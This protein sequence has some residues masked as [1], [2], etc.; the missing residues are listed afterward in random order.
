MKNVVIPFDSPSASS[1]DSS[2]GSSDAVAKKVSK[3]TKKASASVVSEASSSDSSVITSSGS[4]SFT[5]QPHC[6]TDTQS[7]C[8]TFDVVS[9]TTMQ[10]PTLN[11]GDTIDMDLVLQNPQLLSID[12]M[13][14]T[15]QYDPLF[16]SG[17]SVTLATGFKNVTASG[18]TFDDINGSVT[19]P[20]TTT[21]QNGN[22]Q[23]SMRIAEVS[24]TVVGNGNS[25]KS[26][27][28]FN[29]ASGDPLQSVVTAAGSQTNV[30]AQNLGMLAVNVQNAAPVSSPKSLNADSGSALSTA[31]TGSA[32]FVLLQPQNVKITTNGTS[33]YFAWDILPSPELVGY[34]IYYGSVSGAYIQRRSVPKEQTSLTI[35]SLPKGT[36]YYA[37]IR[38]VN[39]IGNETS[40]SQE[41]AVTVGDPLTSSAPFIPSATQGETITNPLA[42]HSAAPEVPGQSGLSTVFSLILL[43]SAIAGTLFALRRQRSASSHPFA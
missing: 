14:I 23:A 35:D 40:F 20:V 1:I 30:I 22:G 19:L 3:K 17:K 15:L 4:V 32:T 27:V 29:Q 31:E 2:A 33:L 42:R 21:T 39:T 13:R 6:T 5:L 38:G 18:I 7:D 28:T 24:F 11:V 16:L 12:T 36:T 26:V 41:V 8:P 37:A 10:T 34:N 43:A 9:P 25:G